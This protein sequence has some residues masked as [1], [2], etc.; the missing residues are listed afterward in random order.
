MH[1]RFDCPFPS[2]WTADELADAMPRPVS[3]LFVAGIPLEVSAAQPPA[4]VRLRRRPLDRSLPTLF[5]V[6]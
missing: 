6:C 4:G 2:A 1:T 5:R 3:S